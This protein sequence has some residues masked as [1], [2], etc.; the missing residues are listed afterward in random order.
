[1]NITLLGI[2]HRT[3]AVELREKLALDPDALSRA[4][5][6]FRAAY[7][8]AELTVVS[9][10]NR[11]EWYIARPLQQP[12]DIDQ[13]RDFVAEQSGVT[14]ESLVASS[15]QR[16]N[17]SAV[18]HLMRVTCGIES[19]VVGEPQII[20]QVK[21]SYE[22]AVALGSVGPVLHLLFQEALRLGKQVRTE[23]G[24]DTGRVSVS[25]VAVDF[26]RQIFDQ[27]DDKTVVGIGAGDMAKLTLK[28]LI[29][30]KPKRLW[31]CNRSI[32]RARALTERLA[33]SSEQGGARQMDDLDEL[34][35]EA[36]IV[37]TSTGSREP[38][39]TVER[40]TPLLKRRRFRPLFIIDI[41]VPRDVESAVG[42]LNNVYLYNID[43]LQQVV[44]QTHEQRSVLAEQASASIRTAA[45]ACMTQIQN[46]DI[47][48]LI[49][50]LR[51]R[52][53][54]IGDLEKQ[55]TIRKLEHASPQDL[56]ALIDEHTHRVVNKI[57]H[58]PV[59][60]LDRHQPPATLGFF[61][62]AL[63]RLFR[64]EH[65]TDQTEQEAR[66]S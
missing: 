39:I 40:F 66:R 65:D 44:E 17:L 11:V 48:Q 2:S 1:M 45:D 19:M 35:V 26:A 38:V 27:F 13:L 33:I 21:R 51:S 28:H 47:G 25:S 22:Q 6:A 50:A 8:E 23:T 34:L 42:G 53:H 54:E 24:I 29:D 64:L 46:R 14:R 37:L 57:L 16:E 30:L 62:A 9:T 7:P 4:A 59:S 3:A 32:D 41:A 43:D 18:E 58:M 63:R 60:Q 5:A 31:L 36:D 52:L 20:G 55:R 49:R 56:P 10:C 61:A 15:I 12:P